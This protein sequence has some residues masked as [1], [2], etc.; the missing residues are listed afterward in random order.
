MMTGSGPTWGNSMP[1]VGN[2]HDS[3]QRILLLPGLELHLHCAA[4]NEVRVLAREII[5]RHTDALV[6][7]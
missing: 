7:P 3:W 2:I 6:Q 4:S 5:D 1:P